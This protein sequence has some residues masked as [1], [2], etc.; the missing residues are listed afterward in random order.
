MPLSVKPDIDTDNQDC[1]L[2]IEQADLRSNL[3]KIIV[4]DY[5]S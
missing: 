2:I 5:K 3:A 1:C 4:S